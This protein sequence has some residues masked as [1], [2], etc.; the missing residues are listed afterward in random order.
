MGLLKSVQPLLNWSEDLH[1]RV[2]LSLVGRTILGIV[3]RLWEVSVHVQSRMC[4][5]GPGDLTGFI[6]EFSLSL[7]HV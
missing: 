5:P 3:T 4:K 6:I 2:R 7:E 1:K